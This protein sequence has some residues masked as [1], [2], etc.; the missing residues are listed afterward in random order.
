MTNI[1]NE[2]SELFKLI[3]FESSKNI[4][5]YIPL[6][7]N[8][9]NIQ[10]IIPYFMTYNKNNVDDINY[11]INLINLLKEFFKTN[12]NLIPLF[13]KNSI[14]SDGNSFYEYLI[15]L[16]LK[17]FIKEQNKSSIEEL[18][19]IININ[20]P[21]SKNNLEFIY[22]NLSPFFRN[23]GKTILTSTLLNK[24][25]FLLTII[26]TEPLSNVENKEKGGIN[27]YLYFNGYNSKLSF[28]LN[29]YNCNHN[30][31]FPSL[32]KGFT[33][34]FWIQFDYKLIYEYFSILKGKV[35]INLIK[36]N[37]GGE[38]LN[39]KLESPK[40]IIISNKN[41]FTPSIEIDKLFKC[42]EWNS[43]V[44]TAEKK[45]NKLIVKLYINNHQIDN[46]IKL[47]KKISSKEKIN[48]IDLF[49]NFLGKVS[50]VLFFSFIIDYHLINYLS[51]IKGFFNYKSISQFLVSVNED[52]YGVKEINKLKKEGNL[53]SKIKNKLQIKLKDNSENNIICCFC[54]FAFDKN[55]NMIDDVFGNFIGKFGV[56]DGVILYNHE[57]K[58]IQ[59]LGGIN[60]LLPL[61]ELMF[62]SLK[63]DNSYKFIDNIFTERNFIEVLIIIEKIL[64]LDKNNA[65]NAIETSFFSSLGLFL[66]KIPSKFF[67]LNIL[68]NL[69]NLI[70]SSKELI[71]MKNGNNSI[72]IINQLL[73]ND[74]IITKFSITAQIEL[75][76]NL[77]EIL[78][79][80]LDMIKNS[81]N[82]AKVCLLLRFYDQERY[83][84][85]CCEGHS[86]VIN[87]ND[88]ESKG[89]I[90]MSPTLSLRI[91]KLFEIIQYYIDNTEEDNNFNDL[92]KILAL[93]LSPCL[94]N[95]IILLYVNHFSNE[96]VSRIIKKKTLNN[97]LQNNF[98]EISEYILKV[99]LLE[100]RINILKLFIIFCTQY[101]NITFD[102]L[103]QNG[104]KISEIV[105]YFSLNILPNSIIIEIDKEDE[106][107]FGQEKY[108]LFLNEP[109]V[110]K[111]NKKLYDDFSI[112]TKKYIK[113]IDLLNKEEYNKNIEKCWNYF[114]STLKI[115]PKKN[116]TENMKV[117]YGRRMINPF[118]LNFL[119]YFVSKVSAFYLVQFLIEILSDLKDETI[120][121]R[122]IFY[123]MKEF[124]PWLLDIVFYY[125]N[126][127]NV[128]D[129]TEKE[130]LTTIKSMSI[131]IICDL[132][133]H[134]R[135]KEEIY[136][137][138]RYILEYSYYY[139]QILK[140]EDF[141]EIL[142]ITRFLLL[143]IFEHSEVNADIKSKIIF[144]FMI[145]FKNSK[146]IFMEENF[147]F[148]EVNNNLENEFFENN[149]FEYFTNNNNIENEKND[150]NEKIVIGK[151][152]ENEV[153][154]N[155]IIEY[156]NE[157]KN[158]EILNLNIKGENSP[159]T[160]GN[161]DLI[162]NSFF[163]GINYNNKSIVDNN[164]RLENI[165]SDYQ[166]FF[167]IKEY[168]KTKLWGIE[169]LCKDVK[170]LNYNI[171]DNEFIKIIKKLFLVY[172]ETKDNKN[173]L[174]KQ[175]IKYVNFDY[176]EKKDTNIMYI[177]IILLSIAIDIS[178]NDTEKDELYF[179]YQQFL[180]FFIIASINI[181]PNAEIKDKSN[182]KINTNVQNFLYNIIGY[183]FT[184]IKKRDLKLYEKFINN[185]IKPIFQ[186]ES[187]NIFGYSKK[188]FFKN[189]I[190]GK[191][192]TTKNMGINDDIN[193]SINS[194]KGKE[195][196]KHVR[197]N[198]DLNNY[199]LSS[200]F[201]KDRKLK[202]SQIIEDSNDIILKVNPKRIINQIIDETINIYQQ[203]KSNLLKKPILFFYERQNF[204]KSNLKNKVNF[205]EI[206]EK[207][208]IQEYEKNI[209]NIIILIIQDME[210]KIN[211]YRN[212]YFIDQS[213]RKKLYR[214]IKK[215]LFSWK[216]FWSDKNLFYKH[217]ENLKLHVKN[218]FTK[219]I[220]KV[221][222][223]PILDLDYYM[224]NFKLFDK[225]KLFNK[226]DYKYFVNLNVDEI[227]KL[228]VEYKEN[229]DLDLNITNIVK[230]NINLN[231]IM[232][233]E[234]KT[235]KEIINPNSNEHLK[236]E[237]IK[238][239]EENEGTSKNTNID[240]ELT[241]L[242][243]NII[244]SQS[245]EEN[246]QNRKVDN[247]KMIEI[248]NPTMEK[249]IIIQKIHCQ[250]RI[251]NNSTK[252]IFYL[253]SLF[254]LNFN[255][256][257]DKYQDL[258]KRMME[259]N[260]FKLENKD[261]FDSC[262]QNKLNS[263]NF[264]SKYENIYNC[265]IVKMTHHI[266]GYISTENEAATFIHYD[267]DKESEKLLEDDINYD[268]E[269]HCC[270]GST[271]KSHIKDKEKVFLEIKYK[272]I[273][274][275]L[276]RNYFYQETAIEIYTFS[277]KS[278]FLNFKNNQDMQNFRDDILNHD[279]FRKI[280]GKDIKGKKILGYEKSFSSKSKIL[281]MKEISL[282]W[283]NN[284]ISTLRYL[285]YLN[286]FSGRSFNDLTQ[287]PVLPWLITNYHDEKIQKKDL[288]DLS[289]P[290]GMLEVSD[291][292]IAR[293]EIFIEF[294][295]TLKKDF[296][297]ANEDFNFKEFL[298]KGGEYLEQYK[299]KKNK[300]KKGNK[301][302]S[303]L[304]EINICQIEINQ[305]PFFYGTHYSCPTFVSH[306]LMRIF[307]FSFIS[308]E[309]QGNKFDDP[310]R[311]FISLERTFETASTL[312]DDI[313]E[314]IPEFYTL[315]EMFLNKNNLNL[316]Q[317]K[318]D[319]EGNEVIV[320]DV[321]M[322]LWCNNQS[323]SFTTELR[324][325]LEK[326]ELNI[327]KWI[328]LIFGHLQ[329]GE[330][331]ETYH[332]I[333]MAQSYENMVKIDKI[334]STDERNALMRLVEVGITPKQIFNKD[335]SQ[336]NERIVKKWKYLYESKTLVKSS[337]IIPTNIKCQFPKIVKLKSINYNE[338]L[339]INE[340]NYVTKIKFKNTLDK[341]IIEE[342][343]YFQISNISS[344]YLPSFIISSIKIPII[345][346]N[347][348]KFVI[349]GGF[350][351]GR[352]E[353][354]SLIID[355]KEKN[356]SKNIIYI[357]EGPIIIMEMTKDEKYL[358]CGTRSG[359]LYCFLVN[360]LSLNKIVKINSH[361]DEIT[362]ININDN[363]NMF[364]TSSLDG[365]VNLHILPSFE[366][367]RSIKISNTNM[368]SYY[369]NESDFYYA[370]N[371]FL[372]SSP[373]PCIIIYI[374]S[375]RVFRNFTI[376]GEFMGEIQETDNSNY[377]KCPIIFSDIEFQE[378][379]IYGTDNGRIK[380][381]K[382][383]NMELINSVCL[384]DG[385]EIVSMDISK[386]KKYC[387]I[388]MK[389]NK[390]YIIK[391]LYVDSDKDKK[392]INQ[393]DT[394]IEKQ[395]EEKE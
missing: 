63:K 338:L 220:T 138:L 105:H 29:K 134:R 203:E 271:F 81:L 395:N 153:N 17:E 382:F 238:N 58:N 308:I 150:I 383:P 276:F 291:K 241:N 102:Y 355:S 230:N 32:Q 311:I 370:D 339:M 141:P 171:D 7:Q 225:R 97:L 65:I 202:L 354:N 326:N 28:I 9:N 214:K 75:W 170:K 376:N 117:K 245:N 274:Y 272:D 394:E 139:K 270:F 304:N 258:G 223:T 217:P 2:I 179:E 129:F 320:N 35:D 305:I 207:D 144:E 232:K 244:I 267:E 256:I 103:K 322:P 323:Y 197:L 39:I 145:L 327:N 310:D 111:I 358:L 380:I 59:S 231:E 328:D 277:N 194:K 293:K 199:N 70:N 62:S 12:N 301:N 283:K 128:E 282:E 24:Y 106:T 87:S 333:F 1:N 325:N 200:K 175:I 324:K 41:Y 191:L 321:E 43:I 127:K 85:F 240:N 364:A 147:D 344:E 47:V 46:E 104:K 198:T 212:K 357:K 98:V 275:I 373:L 94:Q 6:I 204:D 88:S 76:D 302:E 187:K 19:K 13:M 292:S 135:E 286:I 390:V 351:D 294:Y 284:N 312:K 162:P 264:G 259:F 221:L 14:Y 100:T 239:D 84:K 161:N 34:A 332:N 154:N 330:K 11:I 224:P 300:K 122:N 186:I 298:N 184:Y 389:S 353:L 392:Q 124:F 367:V 172:G 229:E 233:N 345:I 31:Y 289:I 78:I 359:Y 343:Q 99:S 218:H 360:G 116:K 385:N 306:Y 269:L 350:W 140:D 281:K 3:F 216:G 27:N 125:H 101:K 248:K 86:L 93:D 379:I 126:N 113:L 196:K 33:F 381:R 222:L 30:T 40:T 181:S 158:K 242:N 130:L 346:Y 208:I 132:F 136:R 67:S 299:Y 169:N 61:M 342:N 340:I 209:E 149:N 261:A 368:N 159:I 336:R 279:I 260:K 257:W 372:S 307:P 319:S 42:N 72:D 37:I 123:K 15:I 314:L 188:A 80:N 246:I 243:I 393:L 285:M 268:K 83:T 114:I 190:I 352:I 165:W 163:E 20:Y 253:E 142:N 250:S 89:K 234:I 329:R 73:L 95:K 226:D 146:I 109:M 131:K 317:N 365:Y 79:K 296:R 265:C 167:S 219:D 295:E 362:S 290:I 54:P 309:I 178:E 90:T 157:I 211:Q 120:E 192:F 374:S 278:F 176:N 356:Y 18:I 375:K 5:E 177:N 287:Y 137:F 155:N 143:T 366:I 391:D 56:N 371:V 361:D 273:K 82:S 262:I 369:G 341:Y 22:Q 297:E 337:L 53:N 57:S 160:L 252:N 25:F 348:N 334:I 156:N 112:N 68:Y 347:N 121:N 49:E 173:I 44:L 255:G 183:G 45:K 180:L 363:L 174:I 335:T 64:F 92:L 288:R 313:R 377:I 331:A 378:Y 23:E 263:S 388:W 168:Y 235:E 69:L 185:L 316:T 110:K 266:K 107:F 4:K 247:N 21:L 152:E 26:Y 387:Y 227:L 303:G 228:D 206:K 318:L 50:S 315:P 48:N 74:H 108:N 201:D 164:G 118:I 151:T 66:E 115:E 52:F 16:Y 36:I 55:K 205:N 189:S 10:K 249:E 213:I 182:N 195:I 280:I 8:A 254:K 96:K 349:K 237:I 91:K 386:D 236:N 166:L 38:L 133:S 193:L 71:K 148:K 77:G 210:R 60:N 215:Q 119:L 384:E 251:I 51:T